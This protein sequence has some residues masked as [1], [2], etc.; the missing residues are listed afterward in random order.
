[1]CWWPWGTDHRD[2]TNTQIL[3]RHITYWIMQ[4]T[5]HKHTTIIHKTW[6]CAQTHCQTPKMCC[7][8]KHT[9]H[10]SHS[11]RWHWVFQASLQSH[12]FHTFRKRRKRKKTKR[13][14]DILYWAGWQLQSALCLSGEFGS[15][16]YPQML[17]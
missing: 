10:M 16:E 8:K 5:Y 11:L 7:H 4:T 15:A 12:Q 9:C 2:V 13:K 3:T 17:L 6:K 1:M 14:T